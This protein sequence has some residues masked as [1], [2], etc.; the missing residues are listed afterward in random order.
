MFKT[1]TSIE[2]R[3]TV[4]LNSVI[5][6]KVSYPMNANSDQEKKR[7]EHEAAK[8]FMR[9]YERQFGRPFRH[10][11]HNEPR[12]PD[13]SAY[14]NDQR[15]DLEIA[16][17]YGS[18]AQA[19]AILGREL[20]PRMLEELASIDRCDDSHG[21]LFDALSRIVSGKAEKSYDTER[22]WLVI[23]NANPDWN[24]SD[25][26]KLKSQISVPSGHAFEQIWIVGDLSGETGITRLA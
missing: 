1:T 21:R 5:K 6:T 25:F 15:L 7:L 26:A 10:I 3:H 14:L 20:S 17:L 13:V 22:V 12:K 23:R 18:T 4:L 8:V 11:W 16:H 19:M 24:N 2:G 9:E